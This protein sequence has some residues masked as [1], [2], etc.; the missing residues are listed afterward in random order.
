MIHLCN[1]LPSLTSSEPSCLAKRGCDLHMLS[2]LSTAKCAGQLL[3]SDWEKK[4]KK[5]AKRQRRKCAGKQR[6]RLQILI[7]KSS[8]QVRTSGERWNIWCSTCIAL[9]LRLPTSSQR[10]GSAYQL[11]GQNKTKEQVLVGKMRR[12]EIF[13]LK[14]PKAL[15]ST[16]KI[17]AVFPNPVF[18]SFR[19]LPMEKMHFKSSI[20]NSN[21]YRGPKVKQRGKQKVLKQSYFSAVSAVEIVNN[22]SSSP[23]TFYIYFGKGRHLT[24]W[25]VSVQGLPTRAE[26]L[27]RV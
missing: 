14:Q 25:W 24:N 9:V 2:A 19:S 4:K 10:N 27:K 13:N 26:N 12:R 16:W 15:S 18:N 11:S 5:K 20:G 6:W 8:R 3:R 22:F 7:P 21:S 1:A 17:I 23:K